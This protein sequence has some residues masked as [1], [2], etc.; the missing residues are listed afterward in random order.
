M[1][2]NERE[3]RKKTKLQVAKLTVVKN[4]KE[5]QDKIVQSGFP[6]ELRGLSRKD[7]G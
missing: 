6:F 1:G 3:E 7:E 5:S 2:Q 4:G